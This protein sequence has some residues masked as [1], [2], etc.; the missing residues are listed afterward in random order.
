[1]QNE[2]I[3]E[4]TEK[5]KSKSQKLKDHLRKHKTITS[6]DAIQLFKITRLASEIFKLKAKGWYFKTTEEEK[7]G[8]RYAVYELIS[9]PE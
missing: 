3:F 7:N 4:I 9:A 1:M 5:K 6:W 2:L 8:T